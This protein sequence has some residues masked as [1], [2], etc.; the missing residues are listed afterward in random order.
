[1][2]NIHIPNR[3]EQNILY[4]HKI[5]N[6]YHFKKSYIYLTHIFNI[7]VLTSYSSFIYEYDKLKMTYF[8]LVNILYFIIL[9]KIIIHYY[10][11]IKKITS[12][13]LDN[14]IFLKW[15]NRLIHILLFILYFIST[16]YRN[17]KTLYTSASHTIIYTKIMSQ[18]L[19]IARI[20]HN[21]RN[22]IRN[23]ILEIEAR[24][25]NRNRNRNRIRTNGLTDE[26]I[27]NI[28]TMICKL[29]ENIELKT[30]VCSICLDE[31]IDGVLLSKLSC[32][33]IYHKECI[34]VSLK[35]KSLCPICRANQLE[36]IV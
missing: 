13:E 9:I 10:R 22:Y 12:E 25:R 7:L 16:I 26:Q 24:H 23:I 17:T 5:Y 2:N 29:D 1:M 18:M 4:H 27:N 36:T 33:H 11:I 30:D 3:V 19:C 6:D 8:V 14:K 15:I 32:G 20:R 31:Y 35:I 21:N 34:D 28:D